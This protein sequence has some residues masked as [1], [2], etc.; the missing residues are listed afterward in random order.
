MCKDGFNLTGSKY[1]YCQYGE[2]TV[3]TE[4]FCKEGKKISFS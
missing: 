2:W 4:P 1:T 3:K